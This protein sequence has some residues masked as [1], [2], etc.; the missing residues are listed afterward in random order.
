VGWLRLSVF[1]GQCPRG[2]VGSRRIL[3]LLPRLALSR[4]ILGDNSAEWQ[5]KGISGG[6]GAVRTQLPVVAGLHLDNRQWEDL[7]WARLHV[8]RVYL[9][10]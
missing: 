9:R 3:L 10:N 7:V 4:P 5:M 1:L 6:L 2:R 8:S